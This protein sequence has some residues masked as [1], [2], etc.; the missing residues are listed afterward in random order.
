M[1]SDI[2]TTLAVLLALAAVGMLI[3]FGIAWWLH[4][5]KSNE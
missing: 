2:E 1:I 5:G 4:R 3:N